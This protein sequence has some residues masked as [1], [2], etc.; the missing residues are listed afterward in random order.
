[1]NKNETLH[2]DVIAAYN[3]GMLIVAG[4]EARRRRIREKLIDESIASLQA[5][6]DSILGGNKKRRVNKKPG[7][8]FHNFQN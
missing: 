1:M 4:R 7:E 2:P 5:K 6:F 8:C 3:R